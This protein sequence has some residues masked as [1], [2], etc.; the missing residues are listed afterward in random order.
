MGRDLGSI[1]IQ[2]M[3]VMFN[4]SQPS[5]FTVLAKPQYV[6]VNIGH[7]RWRSNQVTYFIWIAV[8]S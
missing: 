4:N 3:S 1:I 6:K 5:L 8:F 2:Y 7:D